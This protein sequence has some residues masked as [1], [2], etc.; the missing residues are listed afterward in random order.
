MPGPGLA[1]T[2]RRSIRLDMDDNVLGV[3]SAGGRQILFWT[4]EGV[5]LIGETTGRRRVTCGKREIRVASATPGNGQTMV[6]DR[7]AKLAFT[8]TPSG[9]CSPAF[10]L[11]QLNHPIAAVVTDSGWLTLDRGSGGRSELGFTGHVATKRTSLELPFPDADSLS[12]EWSYLI[13]SGGGA[14]LGS[15]RWPFT[16]ARLSPIGERMFLR[17]LPL[18]DEGNTAEMQVDW[19]ALPPAWLG[20]I[21]LQVLADLR[22]DRR[23]FLLFDNRG[24]FLR[25]AE[26]SLPIGFYSAT[27]STLLGVRV[28][29][30]PEIV[31]YSWRWR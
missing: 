5:W 30:V 27:D 10:S 8:V 18:A 25:S 15:K 2:E 1:L 19:F 28:S 21:Y 24:K 13:S 9:N 16:W 22:S 12:P 11:S 3:V 29:D 6:F 23:R 20:S 14:V 26:F 7:M 31:E 4:P 17:S